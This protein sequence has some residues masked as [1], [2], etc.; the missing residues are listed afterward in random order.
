MQV[1]GLETERYFPAGQGVHT[2][3]PVEVEVYWL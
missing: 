1:D 2:T 3:A